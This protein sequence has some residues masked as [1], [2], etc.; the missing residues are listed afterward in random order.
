MKRMILSLLGCL[1]GFQCF[2]SSVYELDNKFY[3]APGSI[4]VAPNGIYINMD[5]KFILVNGIASDANGIYIQDFECARP[6][7]KAF[8]C[9]RCNTVHTAS[10]KCPD[11]R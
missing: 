10:E 7:E 5:G 2:A 4:Y 3:V 8:L 11:K 1:L 9:L 6:G